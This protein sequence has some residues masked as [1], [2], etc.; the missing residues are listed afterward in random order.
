MEEIGQRY[1]IRDFN[2]EEIGLVV[3]DTAVC[4]SWP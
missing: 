3:K 4:Q 1:R 2:M